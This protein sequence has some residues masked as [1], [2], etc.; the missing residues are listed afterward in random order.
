MKE[1]KSN[2]INIKTNDKR[3][4][5]SY[6]NYLFVAA[7]FFMAMFFPFEAFLLWLGAMGKEW[8]ERKQAGCDKHAGVVKYM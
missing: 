3:A 4:K 2:V 1:V 6:L 8:V 5:N 7:L